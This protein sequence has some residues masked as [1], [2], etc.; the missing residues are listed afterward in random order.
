MKKHVLKRPNASSRKFLITTFILILAAISGAF[1]VPANAQTAAFDVC[2]VAGTGIATG[3][4]FTFTVNG[5]T[6]VVP[7][8]ECVRAGEFDIG[9]NVTVQETIPSGDQVSSITV[10]ESAT[11]VSANLATGTAVVGIG[12]FHN[13]VTFTNEQ[14]PTAALDVCKVAGTGIAAGTSFTF[15]VN[16]QT[17][18][19][20]AGQCVSAGQFPIGSNVT[21]Q[22]TIPSGDRVSS[23]TVG[24]SATLV[25]A[26]LATG[27]AVVGI[28][29]FHNTVTFTNEVI[30]SI[31]TVT[32]GFYRNHPDV[33]AKI[34]GGLGGT[35]SVGGTA[36]TTAQVQAILDATPGQPGNVTFTS[37]LL[38][39]TT[40]QLITALLNLG[41]NAA[42][43]PAAVQSAI[44]AAQA[45]IQVTIGPGGQIQIS[46][47][48][49]QTE[50]SSLTATLT[51]FNEGKFPGFSSCPE[52]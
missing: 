25:S 46:T 9:S 41:G 45:G 7:A 36:L 18:V 24:D 40:Q 49:T 37:N 15:T 23:I 39:N 48:L 12:A 14:I 17:L 2:K 35:L 38:L 27:T 51:S 43:G 4:S 50:L 5:Q 1:A 8:G 31:C 44:A 28:G 29:P 33:V 21:V 11:L 26:N 52:E 22:E 16:G 42:A 30:P 47:T 19:V 34:V 13:T 32:K 6:L 10:G 3:T 20:P